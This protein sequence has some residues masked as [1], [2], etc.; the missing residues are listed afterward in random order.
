[1]NGKDISTGQ[2]YGCTACYVA[3][4]RSAI[5]MTENEK[6]FLNP[7][8]NNN[9]CIDCGLCQKVCTEKNFKSNKKSFICKCKDIE[10][11]KASQSGGAA[12]TIS[13]IILDMDGVVYGAAFDTDF[14]AVHIRISN[15]KDLHKIKGSKYVQSRLEDT[16][17]NVEN[18][19]NNKVVLFTGTP[20]QVNGLLSYLKIKKVNI[21]NLYTLDLICHGVPSVLVWREILNYYKKKY[22]DNIINANFRDKNIGG[23]GS[24]YTSIYFPEAKVIDEYHRQIFYTNLAL[25][26]S[27]YKCEFARMERSGDFTV[28]D[29]WGIKE[30][31]KDFYDENGVSLMMFNSPKALALYDK[32][33]EQMHFKEIDIADYKQGNLQSPTKANRNVN[34]FWN[35]F[36]TKRFTYMIRK[37]AKNN[38]LLNYKYVI[39]MFI[40]K[41]R[42]P[43]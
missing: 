15:K 30:K 23:W 22:N 14:E 40:S 11:Q 12:A 41:L 34:E 28:A 20:C 6:G 17:K 42:R 37:Y 27:C 21:D 43:K 25:R 24:H 9:L 29:A 7:V 10:M 19:L 33:S 8:V 5:T 26:D 2:C 38:I 13:N 16:F 31:D 3:C 4:P 32:I 39:L 36:K 35:D 18:D 1:M